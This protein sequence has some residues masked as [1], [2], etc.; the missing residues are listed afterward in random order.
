MIKTMKHS[1]I[2]Q[3]DEDVNL[4]MKEHKV[5]ASQTN[6]YESVDNDVI[7]ITTLFI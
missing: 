1:D 5:F 6:I 7:I 2:K 3:R 4:F